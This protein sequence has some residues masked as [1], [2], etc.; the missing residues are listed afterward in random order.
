MEM[1]RK[2]AAVWLPALP[3]VLALCALLAPL[4]LRAQEGDPYTIQVI[5]NANGGL[6]AQWMDLRVEQVEALSVDQKH[7]TSHL[8]A[9]PFRWVA[10]D[11]RR[12]A[13]TTELS[14]LVDGAAGTPPGVTA[15][16]AERAVDRAVAT[17]GADSC[18]RSLPLVKRPDT[19]VDPTIFDAQL[20]YGGN[21][22]GGGAGW[23]AADVVFGGWL[24][25]S[26]FDAVIPGGGKSVLALSVTFIFVGADGEPTDID[27][28]G[29]MDM[30]ANEI[31]FN[32][33]FAWTMNGGGGGGSKAFDVQTAALHEIG[34]S[35]ALSHLGP[36]PTAVMNPV[37]AGPRLDLA[38][39]DHA[40]LCSI[41]KSWPRH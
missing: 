8:H 1:K 7:A 25:A 38:L 41:W 26:F 11:S 28:D 34:H 22:G 9:L 5:D 21:G 40:A 32:A 30:A 29:A 12:G 2:A 14:Y 39:P 31:Y 16:D 23:R 17:W 6:K 33:G 36:P 24:P 37:Y 18:L 15:A 10:N 4:A 20:G 19:G 35:L 13:D 27:H 3:A